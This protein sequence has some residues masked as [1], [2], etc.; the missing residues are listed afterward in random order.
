M[1][2]MR[3]VD[4]LEDALSE[5]TG[6]LVQSLS[7]L[8][9]DILVLGAGGKMG[10]TLARMASRA[11]HAAG[12]KRRVLAV[13]RF[14]DSAARSRLEAAGVQTIACDLLD[15]AAL[16]ALPDAPNVIYMAGMKFGTTGNEPMT[17]AQNAYLPGVVVRRYRGSRMVVFSSGN[18]Y[19]L[20][21]VA[22]GGSVET[23]QPR[24]EGEYAWS[25][26]ARERIVQYA[27]SRDG[28]RAVLLRLNYACELRYGVLVDIARQVFDD[29]PVGLAMGSF[30]VIWQGDANAMALRALALAASPPM[31]LNLTGPEVLSV[32]EVAQRFGALLDR[33]VT[34]TGQ[35]S[36]DA[37][38]SNAGRAFQ[39]LGR[40][41]I[42]AER[43]MERVAAWVESGG[44]SLGKP[45]HFESRD[46]RF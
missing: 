3:S 18:V 14:T 21:P 19:G 15:E 39:L 8:D 37:L 27:S 13:S 12:L 35:E 29:S 44:A 10:P 23:D 31:V 6:P 36:A 16:R 42:D 2:E 7:E 4:Q 22:R 17:W 26:L 9:G 11:L 24:P 5:P 28:T 33:K 32:R 25:V 38:L 46:G 41:G 20:T 34:Y 45:T 1:Q 43:L 30:N 40:P